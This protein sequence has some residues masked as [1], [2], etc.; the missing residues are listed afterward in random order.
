M[1]TWF[2]TGWLIALLMITGCQKAENAEKAGDTE[3]AGHA[4]G[5]AII[6]LD[7]V[8]KAVGWLDE[9]SKNIQVADTKLK[10]QLED[11]LR[12]TLRIIDDAKKQVAADAKLTPDQIAVLNSAKDERELN[13]LPLTKSQRDKL[14]ETVNNANVTWRNAL[15]RYQQSLQ[16]QR[17]ALVLGYRDKIRPVARR[18]ATERGMNVVLITS[19]N[20]LYFDPQTADI[21][22]KVIDELQKSGGKPPASTPPAKP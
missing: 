8:A 6:D 4:G 16:N 14:T 20:L 9:L 12:D 19:D 3:K 7:R 13:A 11:E 18:V 2:N 21:T 17:S 10:T 22:D 15:N 1:K 5:V